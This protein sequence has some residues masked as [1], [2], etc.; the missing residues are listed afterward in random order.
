[1]ELLERFIW[2]TGFLVYSF[3]HSAMHLGNCSVISL[4]MCH[5]LCAGVRGYMHTIHRRIILSFTLVAS[6]SLSVAVYKPD[7]NNTGTYFTSLS[8]TWAKS[9][10][11]WQHRLS[12]LTMASE[13]RGRLRNY[14]QVCLSSAK[15]WA[16]IQF[17]IWGWGG[18]GEEA[19]TKWHNTSAL[20]EKYEIEKYEITLAGS[21]LCRCIPLTTLKTD[22]RT[23]CT[24]A[25]ILYKAN[26]YICKEKHW[27]KI[28]YYDRV[29]Y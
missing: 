3:I 13:F 7:I 23:V 22:F 16:L 14:T 29:H 4:N 28:T 26:S 18:G 8:L 11:V 2:F 27:G 10:V 25:Q 20:A 19:K 12:V 1:M 6:S 24:N 17:K 9:L 21:G 5:S 15:V